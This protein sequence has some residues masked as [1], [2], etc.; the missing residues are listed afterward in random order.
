MG[1]ETVFFCDISL[2]FKVCCI[3]FKIIAEGLPHIS[4]D[5]LVD[6][7]I[8]Q[9]NVFETDE[10]ELICILVEDRFLEL[11]FSFWD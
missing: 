3:L 10:L 8:P 6:D 1:H 2:L 7:F 11:C 4:Q 9:L 5:V